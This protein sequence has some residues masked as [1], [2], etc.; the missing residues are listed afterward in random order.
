MAR[1]PKA[2]LFV[3]IPKG[4]RR[5]SERHMIKFEHSDLETQLCKDIADGLRAQGYDVKVTI[6]REVV[7]D[8]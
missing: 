6:E 1:M 4:D 8:Y 7:E 5:S 2:T 3:G